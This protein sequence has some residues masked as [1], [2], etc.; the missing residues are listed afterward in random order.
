MHPIFYLCLFV[1]IWFTFVN[2][3]KVAHKQ[4]VTASNIVIMSAAIAGCVYAILEL[5]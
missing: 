2:V 1:A 3:C 5:S 4:R